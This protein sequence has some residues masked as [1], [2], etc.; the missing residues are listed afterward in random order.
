IAGTDELLVTK[1]RRTACGQCDLAIVVGTPLDFRLGY[2]SFGGDGGAPEA[3]VVHVGDSA[4][5]ISGHAALAA[6]ASGDLTSFFDTL[7]ARV[8]HH[9]HTD[10]SEWAGSLA[11][12]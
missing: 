8:E 5:Q 2:G 1:A 7:Q 12:E 6:S 3:A 11:H 10:W 4:A 9:G